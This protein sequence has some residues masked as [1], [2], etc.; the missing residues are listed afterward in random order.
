MNTPKCRLAAH[1]INR[2][3]QQLL[4]RLLWGGVVSSRRCDCE[5][6]F[7][8]EFVDFSYCGAKLVMSRK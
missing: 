1:G 8:V 3:A 2:S 5:N 4:R 6:R 7:A